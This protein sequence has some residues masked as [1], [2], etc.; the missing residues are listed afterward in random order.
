MVLL[1]RSSNVR[2]FRNSI[3]IQSISRKD[4]WMHRFTRSCYIRLLY[5]I[6]SLYFRYLIQ[7]LRTLSVDIQYTISYQIFF[8]LA[9]LGIS[10]RSL[11]E[12]SSQKGSIR[13]E[14]GLLGKEAIHGNSTRRTGRGCSEVALPVLG[15]AGD[16]FPP[17]PDRLCRPASL[18]L[19]GPRRGRGGNGDR[20]R[21]RNRGRAFPRQRVGIGDVACLVS[22]I[23]VTPLRVF[24]ALRGTRG[25][26]LLRQ[27]DPRIRSRD[28]QHP[29]DIG[30]LGPER[31]K[32]AIAS[33]SS[34]PLLS[35]KQ[36]N[37]N[38]VPHYPD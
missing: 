22:G 19:P 28:L 16:E 23:R 13:N 6:D 26:D 36:E 24:L 38:R 7:F 10:I 4:V 3:H 5:S 37:L 30:G 12:N 29:L 17:F 1:Y 14:I 32:A 8:R 25:L 33:D 31:R 34:F 9:N 2:N 15:R 11:F 18:V 35:S 27:A 21:G 20:G